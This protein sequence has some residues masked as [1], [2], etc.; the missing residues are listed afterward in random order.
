MNIRYIFEQLQR[1]QTKLMRRY[2]TSLRLIL[3]S[4]T[5]W[6]WPTDGGVC[7]TLGM[8]WRAIVNVHNSYRRMWQIA[9]T[10]IM[11][12]TWQR[13]LWVIRQPLWALEWFVSMQEVLGVVINV[14]KRLRVREGCRRHCGRNTSICK[15]KYY[16]TCL[17]MCRHTWLL[18]R[19]CKQMNNRWPEEQGAEG[20]QAFICWRRTRT[21]NIIWMGF[22]SFAWAC[23][24]NGIIVWWST[25]CEMD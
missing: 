13:Q 15:V 24:D 5:L 11:F 10:G 8:T 12:M 7:D 18:R 6:C 3:H 17:N 4:Y 22:R 16:L 21:A 23:P 9:D 25:C 1:A 2:R 14:R 19:S 20:S